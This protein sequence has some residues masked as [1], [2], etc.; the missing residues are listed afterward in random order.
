MATSAGT[1]RAGPVALP[2]RPLGT[3]LVAYGVVGLAFVVALLAALGPLDAVGLGRID[4]ERQAVVDLIAATETTAIHSRDSV[5]RGG[6]SVA[7]GA[8]AAAESAEFGRQLAAALRQFGESLR[9]E[10]LGSRPFEQAA[11]DVEPAA[12]RAEAA[13]TGLD[14]AASEARNGAAGM[15]TLSADLETAARQLGAVRD[16]L[17]GIG[18]TGGSLVW[19]RLVL[20]GLVLWLAIPAAACV[21]LGL[22]MRSAR[23]G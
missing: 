10:I 1:I 2:R 22:R 8:Q 6:A 14:Q 7:A 19:V 23:T 18:G 9:V 13:A 21:W 5:D 11:T 15:A 17:T 20:A 3:A 16:G 4:A 12:A